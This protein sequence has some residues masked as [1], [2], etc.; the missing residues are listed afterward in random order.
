MA[1][2]QSPTNSEV[3][4]SVTPK[5][6]IIILNWNGK[7]F[8]CKSIDGALAQTYSNSFVIV[9]D[10]GS[11]DGSPEM[12]GEKYGERLT[13]V[14]LD[15]NT[16]YAAG[17]NR[18]IEKAFEMDADWIATLNND[19]VPEPDWL[20]EALAVTKNEK[21][22]GMVAAKVLLD[23]QGPD[24]EDL[25]DTCGHLLYPDGLNRGRGRLEPDTGQYDDETDAFFPSGAAALYSTEMLRDVGL[26][27]ETFFA[28][29]DDTDLGLRGVW[30]GY[31]CA[32]APRAIVRHKYSMTAGA[33]SP[34]KA[35]YV[36]RNR[37]LVAVSLLPLNMLLLNPVYMA[38]RYSL[39]AYGAFTGKGAAGEFVKG[40]SKLNL[41]V[42]LLK[43]MGAGV[44]QKAWALGRRY[45]IMK[46]ARITSAEFKT[47]AKRFS[48]SAKEIA[49]KK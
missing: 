21:D 12:I 43:A 47:L 32:F 48:I 42:V 1:E 11:T 25:I 34:L 13:L 14:C 22:I 29:G 20:T 24:G 8:V 39:Q 36:E 49:L 19:A 27:E 41:I 9:V 35:F 45:R 44:M 33:Y 6:A 2:I 37:F 38:A 5:V 4:A 46:N 26:F 40:E 15:K 17:N 3:A 30:A 28:Y 23:E 18:G 31:K 7:D 16:G 10:N